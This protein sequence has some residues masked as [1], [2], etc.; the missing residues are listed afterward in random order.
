MEKA[1]VKA[2]QVTAEHFRGTAPVPKW[3]DGVA[4]CVDFD[5]VSGKI[6]NIEHGSYWIVNPGDWFIFFDPGMIICSARLFHEQYE[7]IE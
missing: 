7:A 1:K 5:G 4:K 2:F 6:Q 3:M